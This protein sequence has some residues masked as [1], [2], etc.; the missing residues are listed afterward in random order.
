MDPEPRAPKPE[1]SDLLPEQ[2]RD[3]ADLVTEHRDDWYLSER[4]PHH[5]HD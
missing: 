1:S 5:D 4:P 3:D 2:T